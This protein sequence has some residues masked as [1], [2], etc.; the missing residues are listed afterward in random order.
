MTQVLGELLA[1]D[2]AGGFSPLHIAL[3]MTVGH[4]LV[5]TM[6]KGCGWSSS[7]GGSGAGWESKVCGWAWAAE[8]AGGERRLNSRHQKLI[9]QLA[10]GRS[11]AS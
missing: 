5:L 2:L 6:E 11:R 8:G 1:V 7:A 10:T 4:G 9:S 3:L